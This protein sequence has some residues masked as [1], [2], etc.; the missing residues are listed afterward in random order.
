MRRTANGKARITSFASS[1]QFWSAGN[2]SQLIYALERMA[3]SIPAESWLAVILLEP[4]TGP[5]Q[6]A[7]RLRQNNLD[8]P[9]S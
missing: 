9:T 5:K 6:L 7:V 1:V 4:F 8:A 2:K 3:P